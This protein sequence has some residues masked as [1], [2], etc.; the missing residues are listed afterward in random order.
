MV[1]RNPVTESDIDP[2]YQIC[3]EPPANE[4]V[5][6]DVGNFETYSMLNITTNTP[7]IE[8]EPNRYEIFEEGLYGGRGS[9]TFGCITTDTF[10]VQL[11]CIP[12]LFAPN[13]FRPDSDIP[14]NRV[15]SVDGV[16][17]A[18]DFQII[19][20]NRWGEPVYESRDKNFAWDGTRKGALLPN[21][22]YPYV[23][24]FK[25]ITDA[26]PRIYEQRGGVTLIR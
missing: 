21:G 13:A 12:Q 20:Y 22:T 9:N 14:E 15:F 3:S 16:Y 18:D 10:A 4:T 2:L 8:F 24:R 11:Q 17:I 6:I 25:S 7:V 1:M 5:I 19:I 26:D 23:I